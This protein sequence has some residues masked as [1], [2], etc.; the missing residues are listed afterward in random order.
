M[1][2]NGMRSIHAPPDSMHMCIGFY[3]H[4]HGACIESVSSQPK[5]W[6]F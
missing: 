1:A 5:D 2:Q 4:V 6:G 3:T